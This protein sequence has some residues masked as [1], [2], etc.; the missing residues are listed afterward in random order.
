[1]LVIAWQSISNELGCT[2]EQKKNKVTHTHKTEQTTT[3]ESL[4]L[5]EGHPQLCLLVDIA[6]IVFLGAC[7]FPIIFSIKILKNVQFTNGISGVKVARFHLSSQFSMLFTWQ[8]Q[9]DETQ[10][11]HVSRLWKIGDGLVV[12]SMEFKHE[13]WWKKTDF[14]RSKH[15]KL[16]HFNWKMWIGFDHFCVI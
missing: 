13:K 4:W 12:R 10:G 3:V 14:K 6:R 8:T 7:W 1:M 16:N 2:L 9:L 15:G 11:H 5:W